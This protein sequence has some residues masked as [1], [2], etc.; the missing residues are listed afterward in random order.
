[1]NPISSTQTKSLRSLIPIQAL[2]W[3]PGTV[4]HPQPSAGLLH[5][6]SKVLAY[7]YIQPSS[8]AARWFTLRIA[9]RLCTSARKRIVRNKPRLGQIARAVTM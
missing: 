5:T 4:P 9:N 1:M 3:V 8:N 6:F 2:K 7:N